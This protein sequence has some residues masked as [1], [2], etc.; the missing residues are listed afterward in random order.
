MNAQQLSNIR[1]ITE[2]I[3]NN[4]HTRVTAGSLA[5][6]AGMS[7]SGFR[8]AFKKEYGLNVFAFT[9]QKRM[10]LAFDLIVANYLP[11]KQIARQCG[12]KNNSHFSRAIKKQFGTTPAHI[13]QQSLRSKK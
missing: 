5:L 12:F 3:Q 11:L 7:L 6:K 1:L 9:Q 8:T 2:F 10:Q 13:R 4:L